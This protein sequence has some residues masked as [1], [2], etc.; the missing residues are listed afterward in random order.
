VNFKPKRTAVVSRGFLATARLSC[1]F[2]LILSVP[3]WSEY[4]LGTVLETLNTRRA[5]VFKSFA[6]LQRHLED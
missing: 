6:G 3:V 4:R 5:I 2:A 1:L